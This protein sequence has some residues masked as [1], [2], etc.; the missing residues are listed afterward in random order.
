MLEIKESIDKLR[1]ELYCI[2]E[3]KN[4]DLSDPEVIEA[5]EYVS[6][7]IVANNALLKLNIA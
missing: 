5:S 4:D 6:N 2:I 1:E 7:A 3:Q